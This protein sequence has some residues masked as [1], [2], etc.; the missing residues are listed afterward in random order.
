MDS[1]QKNSELLDE[2]AA[3]RLQ[4]EEANDTINA[5]RTGQVDALV[6]KGEKGHELFTLKSADQTY[7]V[8]IEKMTEGALT[9]NGKGIILYS[10]SR[11][12]AMLG[13]PLSAVVGVS[14]NKFVAADQKEIFTNLFN[15]GWT[16][17]CKGEVLLSANETSIPF[18]L[19]LT[20]LELDEGRS[21]SIILTDLTKQ[22]EAQKQLSQKNAQ[23]EET[24]NALEQSNGDLQQFA[25]V[26]SHDLQEPLRKIEMFAQLIRSN[27]IDGD[28]SELLR[29]IDKII[30][31][32][33]RM[34]TLII[35][36]LGYSRLAKNEGKFRLTDLKTLIVELVED[37]ELTLQE[38]NANII[39]KEL[40]A[41]EANVGQMRQVFQNLIG[42][43]LKFSKPDVAPQI[44]IETVEPSDVTIDEQKECLIRIK[45]NGIGFDEK[46][47]V[48]I[49]SLFQ[50]LHSK[51]RYEGTGIGLAITKKIIDKHRGEI[52][53]KSQEGVGSEF[54]LRL[55][56]E[57]GK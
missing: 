35:D 4:L 7:R 47:S 55:P 32:T 46:Y 23:L 38:K 26:A 10:N 16:V 37:F 33:H 11:F 56:L 41:I 5:I 28:T 52:Y 44:I 17:D 6:V 54:V 14:F 2:I 20:T 18:Q 30:F 22:K 12:A 50:R 29:H 15:K 51:D 1:P 24:I 42:N 49:F 8:F 13:L 31:S 48:S 53:V 36:I 25:S 9:L 43:A 21:L 27:F 57:Q 19:S 3:L 34:K 45:D 40:P 39:V